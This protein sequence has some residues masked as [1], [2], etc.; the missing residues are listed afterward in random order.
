MGATLMLRVSIP[1]KRTA[2]DDDDAAAGGR[3][4]LRR[5][6]TLRADLRAAMALEEAGELL[7]AARVFEYAGEYAQ[8]AVLRVEVARSLADPS[9]RIDVL[10]EGCARTAGDS[11][12]A[13]ML[14]AA[15]AEALLTSAD[16]N[17]DPATRRASLLEAARALEDA[18]QAAAAGEIYE[19][20]GLLVRAAAAYERGGDVTRLELVLA[21]LEHKEQREARGRAALALVDDA[22]ALGHRAQAHALLREHSRPDLDAHLAPRFAAR[23]DE[24]ER[25]LVRGH[26]IDLRWGN[27]RLTRVCAAPEFRLGRSPDA[28]LVIA[29]TSLSRHHVALRLDASGPRVRV[30]A[31]D[32][33]SKVGTFLD[34]E[35]LLA[36]EPT[37]LEGNVELALG[38]HAAIEIAVVPGADGHDRGAVVRWPGDPRAHVW[39]PRGGPLRLSPDIEV[40]ASILFDR[41]YVVLDL[42]AGVFADL[43]GRELG[44]GAK[45]DLLRGDRIRLRDAPLC[46]EVVG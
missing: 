21:I 11:P 27:D 13:Q 5:R 26:A 19:D 30:V 41:G 45:I 2:D 6:T 15:L 25:R 18:D 23:L 1:V 7:E 38:G 28:E 44:A 40:P 17:G 20:L 33:G 39:L 8:A 46:L 12:E 32:L 34:G 4:W 10:R 9:Q 14:H 16:A 42:G 37:P 22:L 31:V 24:L 35:S 29:A 36:G 43:D 3:S